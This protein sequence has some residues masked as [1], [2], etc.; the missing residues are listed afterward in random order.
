MYFSLRW[1]CNILRAGKWSPLKKYVC[2]E[3]S[4]LLTRSLRGTCLS[5]NRSDNHTF[6]SPH[7][8]L[9]MQIYEDNAALFRALL[10]STIFHRITLSKRKSVSVPHAKGNA[11]VPYLCRCTHRQTAKLETRRQGVNTM[12]SQTAQKASSACSWHRVALRS[13]HSPQQS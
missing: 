9:Q 12:G 10:I 11:Y 1:S 2:V 6:I 13:V 3:T 4:G 7:Y 5:G 8:I